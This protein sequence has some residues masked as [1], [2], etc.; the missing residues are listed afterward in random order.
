MTRLILQFISFSVLSVFF[1][2]C[3]Q[4]TAGAPEA[5][6]KNSGRVKVLTAEDL[7]YIPLNPARGDAAPQAGVL[8]GD[9]RKDV[10]SGT[11][12]RFADGFSSPPHIH[13]ITYRGVVISGHLHNDDPDAAKMW[14]GPGSFWTQPAGE[15]H[16]TAAKPGAPALAFLEI[17]DGPYLVQ[18]SKE[19]FDNGEQPINMASSNFVWLTAEETDWIDAKSSNF[20]PE[21][22][23]LWSSPKTGNPAA[24][25]LKLPS[26]FS[27]VLVGRGDAVRVVM[28]AGELEH[29]AEAYSEE[30]TLLAA[31]YFQAEEDIEN[32][33]RCKSAEDC[34]LYIRTDGQF[35]LN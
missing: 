20:T 27:G 12:L 15:D 10:A 32:L 29:A 21:I 23:F 4:V 34:L 13:N 33:L 1:A 35:Q 25:M 14:M 19:A 2:G 22:A 6:N 8:W 31:S 7:K 24:S 3:S 16:I 26:G 11:L 18:P 28:I 30:T 5:P 17:L 9:I